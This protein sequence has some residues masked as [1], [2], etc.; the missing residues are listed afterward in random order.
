MSDTKSDS[1]ENEIEEDWVEE[2]DE[3]EPE[4][5][6][7]KAGYMSGVALGSP[8][9]A[10]RKFT[11]NFA[12]G[13][14]RVI[15]MGE[16]FWKQLVVTSSKNYLKSS[17]GDAISLTFRPNG[18]LEPIAAKWISPVEDEGKG[19]WQTKSGDEWSPSIRGYETSMLGGK[20]PAFIASEDSHKIAAEL[21][22]R[23]KEA[24]ELGNYQSLFVNPQIR[25]TEVM[26]PD[27][28]ASAVQADGGMA[29]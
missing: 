12:L 22:L 6:I 11:R 5:E 19:K 4:D 18:Q 29:T 21:D 28:S 23:F 15:P 14:T 1:N 24:V 3:A 10:A 2:V 16:K 17:G 25:K 9:L 27:E 26:F 20:V 13:L 8:I 7:E